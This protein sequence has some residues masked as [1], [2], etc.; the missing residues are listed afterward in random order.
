MITLLL[1]LVID[2]LF[3]GKDLQDSHN[4][5]KYVTCILII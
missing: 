5:Q 3:Y 4:V 1:I 2:R